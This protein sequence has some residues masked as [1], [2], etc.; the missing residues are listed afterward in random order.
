VFYNLTPEI[1]ENESLVDVIKSYRD[2]EVFKNDL[3][4][5][6]EIQASENDYTCPKE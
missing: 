3:K 1:V 5:L 6:K 4:K 2:G